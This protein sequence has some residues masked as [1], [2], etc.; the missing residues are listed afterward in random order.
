MRSIITKLSNV[1]KEAV[2]QRVE[3]VIIEEQLFAN[4][5]SK[6]EAYKM[7]GRSNVD[8]WLKEKLTNFLCTRKKGMIDRQQL[9]KVATCSNRF[10]YLMACERK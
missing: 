10:S 9:A 1:F 6:N 3:N 4:T 5:L 7:Y 8:R 2:L